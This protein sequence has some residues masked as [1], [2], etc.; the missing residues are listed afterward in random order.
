VA[1]AGAIVDVGAVVDVAAAGAV[2]EVAAAL[3]LQRSFKKRNALAKSTFDA[4]VGP[5]RAAI[6][7]SSPAISTPL[8]GAMIFPSSVEVL[9]AAALGDVLAGAA[10]VDVLA[11]VAVV[12]GLATSVVEPSPT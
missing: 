12:D 2:V 10:F 1:P 11:G 9:A 3:R 8:I 7:V 5:M 4:P 6:A